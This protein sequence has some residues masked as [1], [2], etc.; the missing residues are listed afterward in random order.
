MQ[1]SLN[2]ELETLAS[3][4]KRVDKSLRGYDVRRKN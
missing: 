3:G 1:L 4:K 2:E